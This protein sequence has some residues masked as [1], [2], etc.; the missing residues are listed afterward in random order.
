M[1]T[2]DITNSHLAWLELQAWLWRDQMHIWRTDLPAMSHSERTCPSLPHIW[3]QVPV[4]EVMKTY[5]LEKAVV[6]GLQSDAGK[7]AWRLTTFCNRLGMNDMEVLL[8]RFQV[9]P[10][11]HAGHA[12]LQISMRR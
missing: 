4:A 3:L 12:C 9:W 6:Q 2:I 10:C 11:P 7:Y 5:K 1:R 8:A